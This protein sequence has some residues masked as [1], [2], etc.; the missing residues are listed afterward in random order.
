MTINEGAQP[1]KVIKGRKLRETGERQ[2]VKLGAGSTNF[3]RVEFQL[4]T[5]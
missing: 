1:K 3:E 5:N 4:R 2:K